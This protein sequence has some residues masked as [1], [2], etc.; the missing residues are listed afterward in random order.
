MNKPQIISVQASAGSGKTYNLAKRYVCL[1]LGSNK[2]IDVKNIIAVT[3]T[4]KAAIEM[5]HRIL[6]YLKKGVLSLDVDE[7]FCDLNLTKN[8]IA[9]ESLFVLKT[10]FDSYDNFNVSTIDSF[11]HHI[12]KSCAIS[13]DISPNF[14]IE[15]DYSSHLL[16]SLATFLQ[17]S[18]ASKN[19]TKKVLEYLSQYL[20]NASGWIPKDNIYDEIKKLFDRFWNTG[21]NIFITGKL[22]YT[23]EFSLRVNKIIKN[24][25]VFTKLVPESHIH[26]HYNNAVKKVLQGDAGLFF[27]MKIPHVFAKKELKYKAG[28]E[29]NL[30]ADDI[31]SEIN[32]EIKSLCDFYLENYYAIYS[33][34][35]SEVSI[36]FDKQS[37]KDGVVF[38]NEINKKIVNFFKKDN[39]I[40][41]EV[42][43]RLSERYKHFLIDEFQDTNF[44]QWIGMK[45]FL[46]E[47]LACGGTFF[48][49]GDAKQAIY[50][51]RGGRP[52][53]FDEVLNEFH[54]VDIEKRYLE[55][56][57]RSGKT[58]VDF[59]NRVFSKENI[60]NFL[61]E[62]CRKGN[63]EYDFSK[64]IKTYTSSNQQVVKEHDYG[65]VEVSV[66]EKMCEN[67]NE[68]IKQK[69]I[70]NIFQLLK[71]FI[72]QDIVVLCR[73]N[74]EILNVSSWL[75]EE[76]LEIESSQTL[77]IKNNSIIKQILSLLMFINSPMN[78]LAFSS[79]IL[80][81][82]FEK[83]S[84]ISDKEFEKF[85]FDCNKNIDNKT[86][87]FFKSFQNKYEYLWKNYF[88]L[89]FVKAGFIPVYELTL[90]ILE[91]FEITDNFPDSKAFV[92]C[93]LEF[94]K[95][96]EIQDSGL[97]NF[98]EYFK[99]KEDTDSLYIKRIFGNGIKI[100]TIHKA[101]G[102]QFPV[103]IMPFFELSAK[104]INKSY[105]FES[106]DEIKIF[107]ISKD[108][109]IFSQKAKELYNKE[110]FS[111]LLS[112]LNG[113]YVSMTRAEYEFYAIVPP[114]SGISNNIALTLLGDIP[115]I[116]GSKQKYNIANVE[117]DGIFLDDFN[118]GYKD[119][120]KYLIGEKKTILDIDNA[121]KKGTIIHYALSSIVSLRN[122]NINDAI[123]NAIGITKRKFFSESVDFVRVK[124]EKLFASKTIL[125]LFMH[126]KNKIYNEKEIV[127]ASGK[128]FKIDKLIV[129]KDKV[130]IVDFK[131]SNQ[132]MLENRNQLKSYAGL[133]TEIYPHKKISTYIVNIEKVQIFDVKNDL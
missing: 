13:I 132:D 67:V 39:A 116:L 60:E 95:E 9:K 28:V 75:L 92:M 129:D 18:Q 74:D 88:E 45:R 91:K 101:K 123:S 22:E 126:D 2:N 127:N 63:I 7:L 36:E 46:E 19:L 43:Y 117:E 72:P 55:K 64:F 21:K 87:N 25:K 125:K 24:L 131:S 37:K 65:Y 133:I 42:Y 16:L 8:E 69:F 84:N 89:F 32:K 29:K 48:Y 112:E 76:G 44:V 119:I 26:S 79:F 62:V 99:L 81:D 10:I 30:K 56:N 40:M 130:I 20:M 104:K 59:N 11:K 115:L 86:V 124:L 98:L 12:L 82:I 118:K 73:T 71:R 111:I 121:R 58:I 93:F 51:F 80:G 106:E 109:A 33:F 66:I 47:S 52:E 50:T 85:I 78:A 102:L 41:P 110:K 97:G 70:D 83:I 15:K 122:E 5:K 54:S 103:V 23:K 107:R 100:M 120:Q 4:N 77:N 96:F 53:L 14:V 68:K 6:N 108:V 114:K 61:N 1:L 27:S 3:F 113:L 49:V 35:Y 17:R 105:F 31:W 90:A 38:L 57:F 94:I 128:L 34:I